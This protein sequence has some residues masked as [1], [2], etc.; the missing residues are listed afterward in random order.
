MISILRHPIW[1]LQ[2][3]LHLNRVLPVFF[4]MLFSLSAREMVWER[5]LPGEILSNPV[6]DQK[7]HVLVISA[8]RHLYC[9]DSVSGNIL[10]K[11]KPGGRLN[12]ISMSADGS[13]LVTD[14]RNR[15]YSLFSRGGIRWKYTMPGPL[16][17]DPAVSNKGNIAL[18]LENRVILLNRKGEE[19]WDKEFPGVTFTVLTDSS[20]V[21]VVMGKEL[22]ALGLSGT[23]AWKQTFAVP[24][25]QGFNNRNGVIL[26]DETGTVYQTDFTGEILSEIKTEVNHPR[27]FYY[28]DRGLPVLE[29]EKEYAVINEDGTFYRTAG[30]GE[31]QGALYTGNKLVV[32]GTSDWFVKAWKDSTMAHVV[33]SGVSDALVRE[34][35]FS[36]IT[37]WG[38]YSLESYYMNIALSGN[39][40][41]QKELIAY[42]RE[43]LDD[44]AF[45]EKMPYLH[46]VLLTMCSKEKNPRNAD[47]RAYTYDL[48]GETGDITY[49]PYLVKALLR[50]ENYTVM[51]HIY[52]ALGALSADPDGRVVRAINLAIKRFRDE[53]CVMSAVNALYNINN[54]N[55]GFYSL[56][57]FESIKYVLD[58]GYSGKIQKAC[59]DLV[60]KM[61]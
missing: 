6:E 34:K 38:D 47:V 15:L 26:A 23:P 33:K 39:R 61:K 28:N 18:T 4:I 45:Y 53:S 58:A 21:C 17:R 55:N 9:L 56:K 20:L 27:R 59:W 50:E 37:Y 16:K 32:E 35:T 51:P 19:I 12:S 13:I 30:A 1:R 49:I 3:F 5:A 41:K 48:M 42:I 2:V 44:M 36:G 29:G 54:Y 60:K 46:S 8:D 52:R 14:S 7:G 25:S 24:L 40:D 11:F 57:A 10:W 43:N 31:N 22:S